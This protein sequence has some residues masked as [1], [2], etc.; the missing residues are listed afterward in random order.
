MSASADLRRTFWVTVF[1]VNVALLAGSLAVMLAYFR[2][3]WEIGGVLAA[4]AVGAGI[5]AVRGYRRGR[6]DKS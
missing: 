2:G 5:R 6:E 4:V 3:E 1:A